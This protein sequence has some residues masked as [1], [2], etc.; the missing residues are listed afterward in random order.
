M[1]RKR[2]RPM[3]L[4]YALPSSMMESHSVVFLISGEHAC[5]IYEKEFF[6]YNWNRE[7]IEWTEHVKHKSATSVASNQWAFHELLE[8]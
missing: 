8:N 1:G 4:S 5:P 3:M 6:L 2:T 7:C